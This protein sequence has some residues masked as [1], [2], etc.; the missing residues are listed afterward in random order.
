MRMPLI[1]TEG[2]CRK[3]GR[4]VPG[5]G[6]EYLC[7]D[8]KKHRPAFD[9]VASALRFEGEARQMLLDYKFNS[10]IWLKEDFVDFLEAMARSRFRI[11]EI[12]VVV[13]MPLT[14]KHLFIRGYTQSKYLAR[15][16]AR[17]IGKPYNGDVLRR[18]GRPRRQSLLT[19]EER[20][21]NAN[22]TFAVK[23][24]S[25][26]KDMTVMVVDDVMTTGAS[27]SEGA[28]MLKAAGAKAVWAVTLARSGRI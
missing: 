20:W 9:R 13:P 16:F 8:C 10:H 12:E 24:A 19:E 25:A 21:K 3:C 18:I 1:P 14:N 7:D 15:S 6:V 5:L 28:A 27:I 17:R 26:I 11:E 23:K 4:D 2:C 22:G